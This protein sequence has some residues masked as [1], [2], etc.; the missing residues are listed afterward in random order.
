MINHVVLFKLKEYKSDEEKK[1]ALIE[2]KTSIEALIDKIE[3]VKFIEVGLN[4]M[5]NSKSYDISLISHFIN[6]EGLDAYRVHPEH[7]KVLDLINKHVVGRA[8]VDY[9]F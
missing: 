3:T 6:M 7:L 1:A 9:E 5:L 4:H 2:I 8:A